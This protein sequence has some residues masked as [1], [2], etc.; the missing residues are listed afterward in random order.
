MTDRP[1]ARERRP[2]APTPGEVAPRGWWGIVR[3]TAAG[4]ARYHLLDEAGGVAFF[5]LLA[6][7]PSLAALV[8]LHGL[9]AD[10]A[11]VAKHLAALAVVA[12]DDGVRIVGDYARRLAANDRGT[13]GLG[14][15]GGVAAALWSMNRAVRVLTRGLN[16]V[17]GGH[18][19]RG[20]LARTA[21]TLALTLGC[22]SFTLL[23]MGAVVVLP[24]ALRLLGFG[25]AVDFLLRVLRWPL[26]LGAV[27]AFLACLYRYGPYR[28]KPRWRWVSWGGSFAALAWLLGSA[29]FSWYV[30]DLGGGD[31]T[32]GALG[33]VIGFMTWLWL[34]AAAVL[35]GA[36]LNA[37]LEWNA[38]LE[39]ETG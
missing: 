14:A 22:V 30:G 1:R 3:H 29:A 20:L 37:G 13:L 12:P 32:Y 26:L 19:P 5:A 28:P 33:A 8:S 27:T 38:G 23:A 21:R 6:L 25:G 31:K 11:A 35:V 39:R 15:A 34:S 18:E 2:G 7:V 9:F 24:F 17:Y 4:V 10:P 16:R 36:A